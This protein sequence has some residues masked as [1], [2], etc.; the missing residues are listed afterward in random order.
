MVID[1]LIHRHRDEVHQHDLG[2]GA[3]AGERRAHRRADDGL[4]GNRCGAHPMIAILR[5]Q[6]LG[7][8]EDAA[9]LAVADV[10]PE[11]NDA[12]IGGHRFIERPVKGFGK[13]NR[14]Q[15]FGRRAHARAPTP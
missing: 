15:F 3:H 13:G 8:L 12:R 1:D 14:L 5:R 6:P 2:H 11:E 10:L 4:F 7:H 9:A